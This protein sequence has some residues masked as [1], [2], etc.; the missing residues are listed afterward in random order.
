MLIKIFKIMVNKF[1]EKLPEYI[2]QI[3]KMQMTIIK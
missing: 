2:F 3:K 1:F